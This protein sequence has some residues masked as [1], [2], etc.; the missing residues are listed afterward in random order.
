VFEKEPPD[1]KNPLLSLPNVILTPHSAA[2][3]KQC[4]ARM[5]VDAA[6][7]VLAVLE[8]RRPEYLFNPDVL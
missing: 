2:L 5:A 3:T 4:V 1:P 8:G 6:Q 7:G